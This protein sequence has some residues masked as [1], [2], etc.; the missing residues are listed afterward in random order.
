MK[1]GQPQLFASWEDDAMLGGTP[2][3][4]PYTAKVRAQSLGKSVAVLN[5]YTY[6]LVPTTML[7]TNLSLSEVGTLY[8][9]V[10]VA[11]MEGVPSMYSWIP[12]LRCRCILSVVEGERKG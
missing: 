12:R 4:W 8:Q 3:R 9:A 11:N 2:W 10:L 7:A 1:L 6:L 5:S